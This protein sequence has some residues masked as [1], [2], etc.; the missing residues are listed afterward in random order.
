MP[1]VGS[2]DSKC[3]GC[4]QDNPVGLRVPFEAHEGGS[5]G[6]YTARAEHVGWTGILHG[7][8][9]FT[10]MDEALGWSLY[11]QKIAAVTA[12]AEARFHKPVA[13]GTDLI[14]RARVV[15]QNRRLFAAHAEIR[16]DDASSVLLA[17][18]DATMF[19]IDGAQELS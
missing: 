15:K 17:E 2:K 14:V 10:L 8:V 13:V 4:G 7:G 11:F 9:I 12:K 3:Y 16:T 5:L 18:V 1:I 19:P 6:R